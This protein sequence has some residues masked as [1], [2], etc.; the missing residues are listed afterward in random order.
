MRRPLCGWTLALAIAQRPCHSYGERWVPAT[1]RQQQASRS[2]GGSIAFA[3]PA[4]LCAALRPA[5]GAVEAAGGGREIRGVG[6]RR[7]KSRRCCG[8]VSTRLEAKKSEVKAE[9]AEFR[10]A[11]RELAQMEA[12]KEKKAK[13][14]AR[15]RE[16]KKPKPVK[17]RV[18]DAQD[19]VLPLG[20]AGQ[21][22]FRKDKVV[23]KFDV[24]D[25]RKVEFVGSFD[26][27]EEIWPRTNLPEI[28]FLGRSN[29]GK[30]SMLNTLFGEAVAKVSKTPGRTRQINIFKAK[31]SND[32]DVCYF[33]DL[34]GYGYAKM[35]KDKQRTI[36][37]FLGMYLE[38]RSN[39]KLLILLAD[40]RR[41]PL[42]S[43]AGVL[44]Y[45]E[46]KEDRLY[47]ILLVATKVDKLSTMESA[48]NIKRLRE[49][50]ELPPEAM[51]SSGVAGRSS[52]DSGTGDRVY[53]LK[54]VLAGSRG[55]G[56]TRLASLF[57]K[58]HGGYPS[59]GMQFATRTLRYAERSCLRAQIWD[60]AGRF[61]FKSVTE[62]FFRGA[63]GAMLVYDI[64]RR[65]TFDDLAR[66][67]ALVREN[68]HESVAL[69]LVGNKSDMSSKQREVSMVEGMRFAR[70]HG[71]DF[72]ETSALEAEHVEEACRQ[73]IMSVARYLPQEKCVW[74][75]HKPSYPLPAGWVKIAPGEGSGAEEESEDSESF[76]RGSPPDACPFKSGKVVADIIDTDSDSTDVA[77][78]DTNS[79]PPPP[80]PPPPPPSNKRTTS[81]I[82]GGD[83]RSQQRQDRHL[84]SRSDSAASS[85]GDKA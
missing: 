33:A 55:V 58:K 21:N 72:L 67:L 48:V 56:K 10:A 5:A 82:F 59:V 71:L 57:H 40:S 11:A 20:K 6:A 28:A 9:E 52:Y 34:P 2:R 41:E 45:A 36:E 15:R 65:S 47:K 37:K 66:W 32:K 35:S 46:D 77:S 44:E 81:K 70:K 18:G 85:T 14:R 64:S 38:R 80:P 30:S 16:E 25:I 83:C 53:T 68:C 69:I 79:M 76:R 42:A 60:M 7:R 23:S 84:R 4:S 43:D 1:Q 63:V 27:K 54:F 17:G 49:A 73:L 31:N 19:D 61:P 26:D 75:K 51:D 12:K 8:A 22:P 39:L 29:V 62:A 74:S 3:A 50:F 13:N 24:N 78:T